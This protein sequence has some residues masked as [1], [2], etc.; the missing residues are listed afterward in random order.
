[1]GAQ[2]HGCLA[3]HTCP[4]DPLWAIRRAPQSRTHLSRKPP[5]GVCMSPQR[6]ILWEGIRGGGHGDHTVAALPSW[7]TLLRPCPPGRPPTLGGGLG[8]VLGGG[9]RTL[10]LL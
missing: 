3:G 6:D 2:L 5:S 10:L 1:M 9:P 4:R 8:G 7:E